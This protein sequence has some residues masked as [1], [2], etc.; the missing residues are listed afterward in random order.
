MARNIEIKARVASIDA[1]KPLVAALAGCGPTEITQDDIF[2]CCQSG[3]LKL[4]IFSPGEGE[5][6]FYRRDNKNGPKESF[7][8]RVPTA[9]PEAL[10]QT[11]SLAY[12]QAGRVLKSRTLYLIGRTRVHLDR[13]DQL[14]DFLE[15]EVVLEE[16][17][18]ADIAV[19][20]AHCLMAQ[21]GIAPSDLVECAYVD[22]LEEELK[23][24][25]HAISQSGCVP[26]LP[27]SS[28][29]TTR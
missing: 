10:R 2:F 8:L 27:R 22:L 11:L 19:R 6:I 26:H 29:T 15:L 28:P 20:E 13:V 24:P 5:L 3:R 18:P 25:P 9:T 1:L 14:G 12:G 16:G 21:L 7:Y 17:E 4:R 23:L